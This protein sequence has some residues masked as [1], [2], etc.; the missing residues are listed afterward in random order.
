MQRYYRE[1]RA[2]VAPRVDRWLSRNVPQLFPN[3][4][5]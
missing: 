2:A 5:R 3:A 4:A 1:D